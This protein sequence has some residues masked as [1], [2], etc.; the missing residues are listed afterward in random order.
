MSIAVEDLFVSFQMAN[1]SVAESIGSFIAIVYATR[2]A[3]F[4]YTVSV[5]TADGTALG[6]SDLPL[7]YTQTT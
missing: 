6:K 7:T 3:E 5:A 1:Y 2:E 4:P